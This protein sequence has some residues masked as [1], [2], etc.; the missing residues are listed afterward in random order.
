MAGAE[1]M[2]ENSKVCSDAIP[3]FQQTAV[4]LEANI[5]AAKR[6]VSQ[7]AEQIIVQIREREWGSHYRPREN[8]RVE[9]GEIKRCKD[10]STVLGQAIQSSSH[11]F[12]QPGSK[13]LKFRYY[14]KQE[15]LTKP[16]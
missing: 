2:K 6:K 14:A 9:N 16:V 11:V 1:L 12:Q 15:E 13:K 5:T 10:T 4:N 8:A 3:E 7:T